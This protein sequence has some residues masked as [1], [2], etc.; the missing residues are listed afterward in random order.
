MANDPQVAEKSDGIADAIAATT[1]VLLFVG[2][3]IY[4]IAAQ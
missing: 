2:A 1:I 3:S 4:W